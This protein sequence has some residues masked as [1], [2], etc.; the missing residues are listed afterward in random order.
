MHCLL[1]LVG[2]VACGCRSRAELVLENAVLLHELGMLL[3]AAAGWVTVADRCFLVVW[4]R[5]RARR[6][7][8]L[9]LVKP[10]IVV[11]CVLGSASA[12]TGD[13]P[14]ATDR[15]PLQRFARRSGSSPARTTAA[16]S[17]CAD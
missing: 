12:G 6:S 7:E 10:D 17:L 4:R 14:G 1:L 15:A 16:G 9:V 2:T 11:R 13:P 5:L 8:V 3:Q